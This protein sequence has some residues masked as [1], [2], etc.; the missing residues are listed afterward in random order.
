MFSILGFAWDVAS[1]LL[2]NRCAVSRFLR[3]YYRFDDIT[4][5]RGAEAG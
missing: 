1:P 5:R 4:G 2:G 3:P